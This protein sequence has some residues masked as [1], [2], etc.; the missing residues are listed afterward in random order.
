MTPPADLP[1]GFPTRAPA[2]PAL[3][4]WL[5]LRRAPV[6]AP[7]GEAAYV[8]TAMGID[9]RIEETIEGFELWVRA[10]RAADAEDELADY[11]DEAPLRA[12]PAPAPAPIDSG[13]FG[14]LGYLLVIWAVPFLQGQAAFGTRMLDAGRMQAALILNG[15]WWRTITPLTLHADSG[16]ILANSAF[17]ALFGVYVGRALGS[18]IGWLLVLLAGAG[19]NA[20]NAFLQDSA[21]SSIGAS[22]GVFGALGLYAGVTWGRGEMR[23]GSDWRRSLAPLFAGFALVVWTGTGGENTD[24]GAHFTGFGCGA[25]LGILA[26]V[27]PRG[28]LTAPLQAGSA[29]VALGLLATAWWRALW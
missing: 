11:Q 28:R 9:H 23:R 7:I 26:A 18:G 6:R 17:G 24:V 20:V 19:G 15:E 5:C 16:H 10:D 2:A 25:L 1:G 21:F 12:P 4:G 8:L 22:T 3:D 27:V 13:L 14:V 29:L